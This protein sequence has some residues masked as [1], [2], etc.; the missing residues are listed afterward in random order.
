MSFLNSLVAILRCGFQCLSAND[1]QVVDGIPAR[2]GVKK[3]LLIL[4]NADHRHI[5]MFNNPSDPRCLPMLTEL[6]QC[7]EKVSR[8]ASRKG[9]ILA[10]SIPVT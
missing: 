8:K 9:G 7:D 6:R 2:L 10:H 5:C 4:I 1:I 3:K